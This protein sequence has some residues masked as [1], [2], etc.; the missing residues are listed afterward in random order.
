MN[1]LI[2][3]IDEELSKNKKIEKIK[4]ILAKPHVDTNVQDDYGYTAL[5]LAVRAGGPEL[6][7]LLLDDNVLLT[8][9]NL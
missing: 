4:R 1:E 2:D 7:G 5:T 3:A 6:V 8:S 9:L